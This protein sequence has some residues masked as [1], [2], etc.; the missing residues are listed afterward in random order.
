[1]FLKKKNR[2]KPLYKKFLH[3]KENVQNRLKIFKFKKKKW[4]KF[5][6]NYEKKFKKFYKFK[7]KDQSRYIVSRYP[8]KNLSYS[9][10]FGETLRASNRIKLFYG[11]M[12]K[13]L[14]KKN[15]KHVKTKQKIKSNLLLLLIFET[16]LDTTLYR[17][18]FSKSFRSAR[19]L[20]THGKILVNNIKI[21]SPNYILKPGDIISINKN[22]QNFIK[23]NI[24]QS[25]IWQLPPKH[26]IINY[27]TMEIFFGNIKTTH[28]ATLFSFHLNLEK[29]ITNYCYY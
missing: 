16:R 6:K 29:I 5:I 24:K 22:S 27:K 3:I 11:N 15:I 4:E 28:Y 25:K 14:F 18:K 9:K 17:S 23:S 21:K 19:Q 13:K 7:I 10:Q 26:L 8:T 2:F 12:P 1:M 20:I